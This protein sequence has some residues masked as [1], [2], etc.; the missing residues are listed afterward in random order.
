MPYTSLNTENGIEIGSVNEYMKEVNIL[1]SSKSTRSAQLFFRGQEADFWGIQ[2]SVFRNNLLSVEHNLMTEPL[3]QSPEEFYNMNNS[4]EIMEKCQHYGLST[5]LLDITTNPLVALFFAC[6][7]HDK[8]EYFVENEDSEKQYPAGIVFIREEIMPRMYNDLPVKVIAQLASYNFKE[9]NSIEFILQKL[10]E[11]R[12]ISKEQKKEWCSIKGMKNFVE[13]CQNVYTV[14]PIM[15]NDRLIRQSGAFLLPGK[16]SFTDQGKGLTQLIMYKSQDSL[17]D[18][19]R[20]EFFYI[21]AENKEIILEELEHCNISNASLFPE[22]EYQL[23]HIQRMNEMNIESVP[24]YEKFSFINQIDEAEPILNSDKFDIS[25]IAKIV[26]DN[27]KSES[28]A[29]KIIEIIKGNQ[30]IDW[31]KRE[32]VM[33]RITVMISKEIIANG[34]RKDEAKAIAE[35]IVKDIVSTYKKG[36]L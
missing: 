36:D 35:K 25:E 8:E 31:V 11:D 15:N 16:F 7:W 32:S 12:V 17:R 19:F 34:N 13:I 6:A 30:E 14:M 26:R 33:S 2:P 29:E 10:L 23:R 24:S 5:R 18:Y 3:R 9:G 1:N 27:I 28:V 21:S 20:P 4:F 22:L